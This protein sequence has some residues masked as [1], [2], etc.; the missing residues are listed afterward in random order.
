MNTNNLFEAHRQWRDRPADERFESLAQMHAITLARRNASVESRVR[1]GQVK[2][3]ANPEV[4]DLVLAGAQSVA[5]PSNWAFYQLSQ[6]LDVPNEYIRRLP[7]EL[8]ALN[9]NHAAKVRA[10]T[11]GDVSMVW[12]NHN[13]PGIVR[14][15]TGLGYQRLWD[16]DVIEWLRQMTQDEQNGWHRP[17]ARGGLPSGLY[18]GD[19]NMFAFLVNDDRRI[20]DG[21]AEGLGRGF[22]CWNSEVRQMSFG[23]KA[24]LYRYVCGNHIVWGAQE[25]FTI[26]MAHI[27]EGMNARALRE[28]N[29][30]IGAY[31]DSSPEADQAV[32][33]AARVKVIAPNVEGAVDWL[34]SKK[35]GF[36]PTEAEEIVTNVVALGK[37]PT[38]LW[39][40]VNS[41]TSLSQDKFKFADGRSAYDTK[42]GKMLQVVF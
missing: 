15:F 16:S 30:V 28:L 36:K 25:L 27:G 10:A 7:P 31:V 11:N 8:A 9:L 3:E 29:R 17:P 42:A 35:V 1:M 38:N 19:R 33:D 24:F 37:D 23:F 22:F 21:S 18:A 39:E 6:M 14:C 41:A 4:N 40:L 34:S 5:I 13:T 26:R 32:I 12:A 2:F 20:D